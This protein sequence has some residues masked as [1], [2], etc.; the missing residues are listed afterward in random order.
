MLSIVD[1]VALL[2]L[3][4]QK[5]RVEVDVSNGLPA[6]DIIG[7][8]DAAVREAKDRVRTAIK[9]SGLFFPVQRIT[10]NLAPADLRKEGP[11][12]DLP[13]AVGILAATGQINPALYGDMLFLGELSLDGS[14]R[15]V[16]GV[17]PLVLA[18]RQI[19]FKKVV[20]PLGN[21]A[22]AALVQDVMVFGLTSLGQLSAALRGELP[23]E[24]YQPEKITAEWSAV[25]KTLDFA[26]IRGQVAA[27]RA[28]E[29]AAAGG[30]NVLMLGSPGCG[31]TMLARRLPSILPDLTFDEAIEVTKIYSLAGQLSSQQP[32][33]TKRPFRAP[34][35]TSSTASLVGGGRVPKPGE[36]SLAHL[37][38]LFMDELPEFHKDT[39]EALRQPLEDGCVSVSRVAA[40]FIFPARIMLVGAANPCPCGFLLDQEKQCSCTPYQV[41]KYINRISGPLLDRID[42]HIEVPKISFTELSEPSAGETSQ[43]IKSRVEK[44][45]AIQRERFKALAITCNAAMAARDVRQ[46]CKPDTK[47]TRLLQDAFKRMSLSPR[48]HDRILKVA[49]TIADLEGSEAI[50]SQHLAE[51]IQYRGLDRLFR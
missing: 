24:H 35:H 17:L 46:F 36:I 37:G 1:S 25:E 14:I 43:E 42:I 15:E 12:F 38:I 40:S 10:V 13:I 3:E 6:L 29:V 8:P 44:A 27:K 41:Q 31:K 7:L 16:N 22:E 5:V 28:M 9:N 48:S 49:R 34:H 32:L 26:D 19:G 30:H 11:F 45:R 51:A 4:G 39:L 23:L 20:V 33:M 2:G 21:A 50:C 18:A 47:G